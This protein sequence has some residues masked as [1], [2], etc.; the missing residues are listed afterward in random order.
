MSSF[1]DKPLKKC[2]TDKRRMI[3]DLHRGIVVDMDESNKNMYYLDNGLL[4]NE[5]YKGDT[6]IS[7]LNFNPPQLIFSE[8]FSFSFINFLS[9]K[10]ILP[11][12]N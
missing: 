4:L 3:D 2:H 1:K 8:I 10:K 6:N 9:F 12:I 5:Y 7:E 11:S